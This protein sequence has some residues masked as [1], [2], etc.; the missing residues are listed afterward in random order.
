MSSAGRPGHEVRVLETAGDVARAAREELVRAAKAAIDARGRF[1]VVLSGGSTPKA[2]YGSLTA[3]DV[4]WGK[5]HLFF[6][7]ERCVSP[8]RQESNFKMVQEALLL[9]VKIPPENVHRIQGEMESAEIAAAQY[10]EELRQAF[11]SSDGP[12]HFDLV[13]LGLGTD[14]HTASLFPGCTALD[15]SERWVAAT[16]VAKL[17]RTRITLTFPVLNRAALVIFL[18]AGD[19]KAEAARRAIEGAPAGLEVPARRIDPPGGRVLW[20]LDRLAATKLAPK[21]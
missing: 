11:G 15:E 16:W 2:L 10:E 20:L 17:S 5:V 8:E 21:S 18:V 1:T 3:K 4:D 19:E 6:G 14:G 7:D 9:R 12:P 13:L